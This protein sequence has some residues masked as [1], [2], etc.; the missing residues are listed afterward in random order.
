M[1][2]VALCDLYVSLDQVAVAK[3]QGGGEIIKNWG[4]NLEIKKKA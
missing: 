4:E 1:D 2:F 3:V